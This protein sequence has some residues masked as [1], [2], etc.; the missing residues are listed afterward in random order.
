MSAPARDS[1]RRE[2]ILD[3]AREVFV[4]YGFRRT[5]LDEI[6]RAAGIS[7]TGLYHHFASKEELFQAVSA[8]LHE[9]SL[10]TA[11]QA[12]ATRAPIQERLRAALEAKL[13][14]IFELLASSRHGEE[15][16]DENNRLCGEQTTAATR[17]YERIFARALR[18]ADAAGEIDL[19]AAGLTPEA[20]AT[21]LHLAA[22]GVAQPRPGAAPA[23]LRRRLDQ[24]VRLFVAGLER[25]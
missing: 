16:L 21:L 5:S 20:A 1:A 14:S 15:L 19:A 12:V 22:K 23:Q 25:R 9:R 24:L 11:E 7:R 8:A 17:R 2:A 13:G 3:A 18:E 6:A 4:H 10:E